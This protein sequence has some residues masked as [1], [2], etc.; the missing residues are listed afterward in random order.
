MANWLDRLFGRKPPASQGFAKPHFR[1]FP[2]AYEFCAGG[3]DV[4]RAEAGACD[5][6]GMRDI[7]AYQGVIYTARQ[8]QPTVCAQCIADGRLAKYLNEVDFGLHDAEVAE[9]DW[10]DPL[11]IEVQQRTPGFATFNAFEWPVHDGLPM[12]FM[13]YGDEER[14]R[15]VSDALAAMHEANEGQDCF[16][17]PNMLLFRQVDGP[18]WRAVFDPD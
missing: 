16:P 13:G 2:G 17:T 7:F 3:Q 18:T 14:W 1:F 4:F 8:D 12:A 9:L 11:V 5:A 10:R 15:Y 6:C